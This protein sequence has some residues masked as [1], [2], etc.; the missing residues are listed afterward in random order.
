MSR[1]CKRLSKKNRL[2]LAA[3]CSELKAK[4]EEGRPL[5]AFGV[6]NA[7]E[8]KWGHRPC[9]FE[10]AYPFDETHEDYWARHDNGTTY[11]NKKRLAF[12]KRW[13]AKHEKAK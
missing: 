3:L 1:I 6:C 8:E 5:P 11:K 7:F 13:A 9:L 2:K 12:V 4:I 10:A